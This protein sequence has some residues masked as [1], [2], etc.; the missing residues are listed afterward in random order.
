MSGLPTVNGGEAQNLAI[1]GKLRSALVTAKN[2]NP[3][4]QKAFSDSD[5]VALEID[6]D[7]AGVEWE[8]Y[9]GEKKELLMLG[10]VTQ[11]DIDQIGEYRKTEQNIP[12]AALKPIL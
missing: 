1:I 12:V 7:A 5:F 4:A 8:E 3:W 11:E 10:P 2:S 6:E 9:P